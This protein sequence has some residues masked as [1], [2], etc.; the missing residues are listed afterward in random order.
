MTGK[1]KG[2]KGVGKRRGSVTSKN[3]CEHHGIKQVAF[4]ESVFVNDGYGLKL[5]GGTGR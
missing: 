4:R 2:K 3:G 5:A 1:R